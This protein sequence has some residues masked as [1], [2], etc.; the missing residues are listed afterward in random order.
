M[1]RFDCAVWH[2]VGNHGSAMSAQ[3]GLV[4]HHAVADNSLFDRFNNPSSQVSSTFWVS[5]Q[6]VIEQYVDSEVV[7]WANGT[8]QANATYCS[9]ETEGCVSP[10]YAEPMTHEMITALGNLYAEGHRRHGWPNALANTAGQQGFAY[11]RLFVATACP[12]DVRVNERTNILALA[13]GPP[14]T[15]NEGKEMIVA[16]KSGNGYWTTTGDGAVY[17]FG[18]AVYKGNAMGKV[19]GEII[20]IAGKGNDGYWLFASDGGIFTFGS[21]LFYGRPDRT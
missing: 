8:G 9:V 15:V 12:C 3:K 18:D 19:T 10:P 20:G 1:A 5:R 21:A 6:G 14:P 17:A 11:H 7:A 16:T 13:F 4:L 2:P